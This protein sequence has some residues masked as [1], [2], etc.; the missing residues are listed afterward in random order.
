MNDRYP[1]IG[2]AMNSTDRSIKETRNVSSTGQYP[3]SMEPSSFCSE[4]NTK[5]KIEDRSGKVTEIHSQRR[6]S[7]LYSTIQAEAWYK[8]NHISNAANEPSIPPTRENDEVVSAIRSRAAIHT[9]ISNNYSMKSVDRPKSAYELRAKYKS[10]NSGQSRP[11]EVRRKPVDNNILDDATI[12]N[13]SA[14]PYASQLSTE[15]HSN[16]VNREN[17]PPTERPGLAALSS[18]EWLAAGTGK[19]R[20]VRKASSMHPL[21]RPSSRGSPSPYSPKRS[22]GQIL[23]TNW[24][25]EKKSHENSP[26]FV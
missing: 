6:S 20:D 18:S 2:T 16:G 4:T 10:N 5:Q 22:P 9:S 17:N 19:S 11:L 21:H 13:I 12:M 7:K 25:D 8:D 15:A 14:G 26:A 3:E 23:V 1:M 24:L